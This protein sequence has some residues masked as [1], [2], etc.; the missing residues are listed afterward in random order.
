M[1]ITK[2]VL[3]DTI[4]DLQKRVDFLESQKR[5]NEDSYQKVKKWNEDL[6][7]KVKSLEHM[8]RS[9]EDT[10]CALAAIK[11]TNCVAMMEYQAILDSY[12]YSGDG[13]DKPEIPK[14]PID[15]LYDTIAHI[16][17]ILSRDVP[18]DANPFG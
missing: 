3:E 16:E 15:R 14:K 1:R 5:I 9:V 17:G 7:E 18:C 8:K 6:R 13:R 2:K 10:H 4:D 11:A 12:R